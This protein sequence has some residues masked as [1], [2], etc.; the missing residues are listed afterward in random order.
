MKNKKI[1]AKKFKTMAEEWFTEYANLNLKSTTLASMRQRSQRVYAEFGKKSI[2]NI[3]AKQIQDFVNSLARPG[4]NQKTGEP[5]SSKTITHHLSFISDVFVYAIRTGA[6]TD[7]PCR[8]VVVPK[9]PKT[10]KKIYSQEETALLFSRLRGEPL[11]YQAFFYLIAYSG[12]RRSEMLGL[13]WRD[14]DFDNNLVSVRRSSNYTSDKGIYTDSTKTKFS[15]RTLKVSD[16]IIDILCQLKAEQQEMAALCDNWIP[17]DRLFIKRNGSPMNPQTPY[18]WLKE[19]C[20]RNDMEF[21]GIHSFRHFTASALISYGLDVTSVS[22]IL[23]HGCPGTTLNIYSHAFQT[24]Q[25]KA[26][27]AMDSAFL[28]LSQDKNA[29]SKKE[30]KINVADSIKSL[31]ELAE[32]MGKTLKIEFV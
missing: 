20:K 7:N 15:Y 11:K 25:A 19:F 28:F 31:E 1:S 27:A 13:E 18:G 8:S 24:A 3:T 22:R 9:Q 5:L 29:I 16:Y 12:F 17:S 32:Q 4:A 10:E 21:H 14:I 6:C 23:G 30:E 26:S 2:K